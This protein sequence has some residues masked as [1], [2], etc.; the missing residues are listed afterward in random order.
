MSEER[1][2]PHDMI[3]SGC[4]DCT[5]RDGGETAERKRRKRLLNLLGVVA[6]AYTGRCAVC[7]AFYGVGEPIKA[8]PATTRTTEVGTSWV[9]SCCLTDDGSVRAAD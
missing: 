7:G 2:I 6:A 1:C 5:G 9:G 8:L 4:A 3:L